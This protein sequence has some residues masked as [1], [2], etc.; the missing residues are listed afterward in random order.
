MTTGRPMTVH[1]RV[2]QLLQESNNGSKFP[3][4]TAFQC[5][6]GLLLTA[7][8]AV[9]QTNKAIS[10]RAYEGGRQSS[11]VPV[12]V[13]G[14]RKGDLAVLSV[15][16]PD[17]LPTEKFQVGYPPATQ[18]SLGLEVMVPGFPDL[19]G[20]GQNRLRAIRSWIQCSYEKDALTHYELPHPAFRGLSGSPV[21]F[22]D[23]GVSNGLDYAIGMVV[24]SVAHEQEDGNGNKVGVAY[25]AKAVD[26]REAL[27]GS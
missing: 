15:K 17:D 22:H 6:E 27:L 12:Q 7:K 24:E 26:L 21:L 19:Q 8:L 2:F 9:E 14:T 10:V 23:W 11:D 1:R 25:W 4:G 13:A 20:G 5:Q 3:I 18:M 16:W